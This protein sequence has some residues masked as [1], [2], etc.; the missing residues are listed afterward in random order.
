MKN[1][2]PN[3]A[4]DR[5]QD[6]PRFITEL[7]RLHPVADETRRKPQEYIQYRRIESEEEALNNTAIGRPAGY[8]HT[9]VQISVPWLG[10][11]IVCQRRAGRGASNSA[12]CEQCSERGESSSSSSSWSH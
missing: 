4:W 1:T 6:P 5:R 3:P 2:G 7:G 10:N 12:C 9:R 11:G 8:Q